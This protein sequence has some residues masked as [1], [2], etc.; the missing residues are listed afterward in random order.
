MS[1]NR[2]CKNNDCLFQD[3]GYG[4]RY[5]LEI[6]LLD[7]LKYTPDMHGIWPNCMHREDVVKILQ[8][9]DDTNKS[10]FIDLT[11]HI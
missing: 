1:Y 5:K 7:L 6:L 10:C 2:D 3:C 9:F 11:F 4:N 8:F